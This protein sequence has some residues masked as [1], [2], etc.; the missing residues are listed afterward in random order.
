MNTKLKLLSSALFS[1]AFASSVPSFA[2]EYDNAPTM[3][4]NTSNA[5]PG[6]LNQADNSP[7]VIEHD[8]GDAMDNA[9][10]KRLESIDSNEVDQNN[11]STGR[12]SGTINNGTGSAPGAGTSPGP[13]VNTGPG[14]NMGSG[15]PSNTP[16][17]GS[18]GA[19][20]T[21]GTPAP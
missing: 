11:R 21:S 20:G 15:T 7:N 4:P 9:R 10:Q 13:G 17:P 14:A 6:S 19:T 18:G 1:V 3:D 16:R 12:P 8:N 2:T 5:M